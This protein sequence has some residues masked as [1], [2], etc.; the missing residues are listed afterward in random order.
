[1]T[2]ATLQPVRLQISGSVFGSKLTLRLGTF[3]LQNIK[4]AHRIIVENIGAVNLFLERPGVSEEAIR[5]WIN[6]E[7]EFLKTTTRKEPEEQ[8]V[9]VEYAKSLEKLWEAECV[10]SRAL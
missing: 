3:I 9:L 1:M 4:Q 6:E 8:T 10:E 5:S 2:T 7:L